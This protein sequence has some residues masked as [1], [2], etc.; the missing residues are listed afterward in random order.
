MV[1]R[2]EVEKRQLHG[3]KAHNSTRIRPSYEEPLNLPPGVWVGS[4]HN[5]LS[6]QKVSKSQELVFFAPWLKQRS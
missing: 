3:S 2:G 6:A 5:Q 1:R 4:L